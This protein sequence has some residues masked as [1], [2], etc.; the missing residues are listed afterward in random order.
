MGPLG[1]DEQACKPS[2][3]ALATNS[4]AIR[5]PAPGLFSMM[6]GWPSSCCSFSANDIGRRH[7]RC[8]QADTARPDAPCAWAR[9]APWPAPDS[10][11][12][13][14][15]ESMQKSHGKGP[16]CLAPIACDHDPKTKQRQRGCRQGLR[17]RSL[18]A[19]RCSDAGSR[20]SSPSFGGC[21]VE[22]GCGQS[23]AP[24]FT[25][26]GARPRCRR[27]GRWG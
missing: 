19:S 6:K 25:R 9:S 15:A 18:V 27:R 4:P 12:A 23:L 2:G 16:C 17:R 3:S 8:R 13:D 26:S 21:R 7:R 5:P 11:S 10:S 22:T 14:F 1:A 20:P 24:R